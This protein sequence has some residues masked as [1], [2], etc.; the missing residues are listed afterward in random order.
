M[1]LFYNIDHLKRQIVTF[2]Q[3]LYTYWDF[4]SAE[5]SSPAS[6]AES[7]NFDIIV[8]VNAPECFA[9]LTHFLAQAVRF[10]S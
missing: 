4:E 6:G 5:V 2:P 1:F 10:V 9:R 3:N 8:N 7:K